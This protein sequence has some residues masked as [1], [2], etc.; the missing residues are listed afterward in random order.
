MN[1]VAS[2]VE[3]VRSPPKRDGERSLGEPEHHGAR[4]PFWPFDSPQVEG[5]DDRREA[6]MPVQRIFDSDDHQDV[7]P[8]S[9]RLGFRVGE[10]VDGIARDLDRPNG[11][12]RQ[13]IGENADQ[14]ISRGRVVTNGNEELKTGRAEQ[15]PAQGLERVDRVTR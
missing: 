13:R 3:E 10:D 2:P 7:R 1:R 4:K 8:G 5:G 6:A 9:S 11:P 12:G 15:A 14:A